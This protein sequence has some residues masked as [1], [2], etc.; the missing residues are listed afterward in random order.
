MMDVDHINGWMVAGAMVKYISI[1]I[2]TNNFCSKV[3]CVFA[4]KSYLLV[5]K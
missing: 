1:S 2:I 4:E 3:I 5:H